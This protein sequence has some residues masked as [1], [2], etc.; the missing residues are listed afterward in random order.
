MLATQSVEN[1]IEFANEV[2]LEVKTVCAD[3]VEIDPLPDK[4]DYQMDIKFGSDGIAHQ[5]HKKLYANTVKEPLKGIK[6]SLP[7]L[8][9]LQLDPAVHEYLM[10]ALL[11]F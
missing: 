2:L 10:Y 11:H 9:L 6:K 3:Q 8:K 5:V 4:E 7:I 1:A